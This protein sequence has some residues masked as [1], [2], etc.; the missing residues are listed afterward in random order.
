MKKYTYRVYARYD[1][2]KEY[3]MHSKKQLSKKQAYEKWSDIS[4]N[5]AEHRAPIYH[6]D[7]KTGDWIK[8]PINDADIG[9]QYIDVDY[10]CGFNIDCN[11]ADSIEGEFKGGK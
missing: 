6:E 8:T 9:V 5:Y 1:M 7:M 4:R 3:L 11:N 10:D 2:Y